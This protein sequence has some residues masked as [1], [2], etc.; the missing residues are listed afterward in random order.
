VEGRPNTP[1]RDEQRSGGPRRWP[2]VLWLLVYIGSIFILNGANGKWDPLEL[3][4]GTG[5]A[6]IACALG[7]YLALGPWPGRPRPRWAALLIG[8]VAAIYGICALA[9]AVFAGPA[10]A[11]ATLLAGIVPMTAAALWVATVRA[12]TRRLAGDAV[13]ASAGDSD[14]PFPGVG[15]DDAHPLGDTPEIHDDIS[16]HELPPGHPAR[17]RA[18]RRGGTR[19][20]RPGPAA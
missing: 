6:A 10:Y 9:A 3:V 1:D 20:G 13:D 15:A 4:L 11:I 17:R 2:P 12:K 14:D 18:D 16:S 8:G 19:P 7:V 5:L